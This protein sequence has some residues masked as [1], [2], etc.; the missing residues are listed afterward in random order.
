MWQEST[1]R[2]LWEGDLWCP[3][4]VYGRTKVISRTRFG[5]GQSHAASHSVLRTGLG[6]VLLARLVVPA[7]W[8]AGDPGL[9]GE[10]SG[11]YWFLGPHAD[12]PP[13]SRGGGGVRHRVIK[14]FG[15]EPQRLDSNPDLSLLAETLG[16]SFNLSGPPS[17]LLQRRGEDWRGPGGGR[18]LHAGGRPVSTSAPLRLALCLSHRALWLCS[19]G[20]KPSELLYCPFPQSLPSLLPKTG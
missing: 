18:A 16:R 17:P 19:Q 6:K 3:L 11:S 2:T 14:I 12:T 1:G 9:Q 20:H 8:W 15:Q 10:E 13:A 7:S 5:G 4:V